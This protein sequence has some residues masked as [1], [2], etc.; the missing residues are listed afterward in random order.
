MFLKT[1]CIHGHPY[2]DEL[3]NSNRSGYRCI[4]CV[5]IQIVERYE[6][7]RQQI[8]TNSSLYNKKKRAQRRYMRMYMYAYRRQNPDYMEQQRQY[9]KAYRAKQKLLLVSLLK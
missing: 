5:S 1:H 8:I 4:I 7:N 6:N 2:F 9:A 3:G